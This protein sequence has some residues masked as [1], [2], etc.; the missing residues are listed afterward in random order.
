MSVPDVIVIGAGISG[1]SFAWKAAQSGKQV[2]VLEKQPRIGGCF[3]SRRYDDGF[4]YEMG[5]H[6]VYNSYSGF[7]DIVVDAG[8]TDKLV[9]RGPA[10]AHFGLLRKGMIT[11]LT[12]PK[13]LLQL[14]WPA[15][16]IHAPFGFLRG[17]KGKTVA[18][19]YS[20]LLGSGNFHRLFAPFFAAVPSQSANDFPVEGPGSLFKTRPHRE[21]FPRSFGFHG[22]LQTVCDAIVA[23]PSIEIRQGISACRVYSTK[24]G[25]RI[26]LED[27]EELQAPFVAVAATHTESAAMLTNSFPELA[28]AIRRI[29]T[30]TVESLGIRIARNKGWMPDCAFVVPVN[31]VFFSAVTRDPF[32][33]PHYRAFAFHFR[34]GLT[35]DQKIRRICEI[36]HVTPSDLDGVTENSTTL[37]SPRINH[38]ETVSEMKKL[39]EGHRLALVGNYFNGLAVEDCISRSFSEW[40]RIGESGTDHGKYK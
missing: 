29:H 40:Q 7:L 30:V 32:P 6:T 4:W 3:Y 10:R 39:L 1:L 9:P 25:Y 36:L 37:P 27:G 16:A 22:G 24:D 21:G 31:D 23:H 5:A 14:N 19:Y 26:Q 35:Q 12:P 38:A 15:A 33:D 11:W 2:L 17:K 34:P 8:L 18:Q 28:S 20:G 13:I